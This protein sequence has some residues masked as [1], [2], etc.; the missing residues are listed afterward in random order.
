MSSTQRD[1]M[2]EMST[3]S[4][5]VF[6]ISTTTFFS[7]FAHKIV[8]PWICCCEEKWGMLGIWIKITY[9]QFCRIL[10]PVS[11]CVHYILLI[12]INCK[13]WCTSTCGLQSHVQILTHSFITFWQKY[14]TNLG[15]CRCMPRI[16]TIGRYEVG[17]LILPI[18]SW[19]CLLI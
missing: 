4:S 19:K 10:Q 17:G 3:F 12:S 2:K 11:S 16:F 18:F 8:H 7:Y 6:L 15:D 5:F 1:F 14:S 9:I 13:H